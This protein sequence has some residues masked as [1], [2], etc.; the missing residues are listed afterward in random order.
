[1]NRFFAAIFSLLLFSASLFGRIEPGTLTVTCTPQDSGAASGTW[2]V[3]VFCP[4]GKLFSSGQIDSSAIT[5]SVSL[6]VETVPGY[7]AIGTY[8]IELKSSLVDPINPF[9]SSITIECNNSDITW[10]TTTFKNF[11]VL[12][13]G[14]NTQFSYSIILM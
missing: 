12:Q 1:M 7:I 8:I 9:L 3:V 11:P 2:E 14:E 6:Q 5:D 4:C 13:N 10:D